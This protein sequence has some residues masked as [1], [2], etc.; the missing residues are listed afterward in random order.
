MEVG[1]GEKGG[2]NEEGCNKTVSPGDA[3]LKFGSQIVRPSASQS[4]DPLFQ[5]TA[6]DPECFLAYYYLLLIVPTPI[7]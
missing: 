3:R 6:F 2:G 7:Y 5:T 1:W 4:H